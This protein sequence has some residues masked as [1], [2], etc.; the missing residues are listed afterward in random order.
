[1][2]KVAAYLQNHILG[3]VSTKKSS[4]EAVSHDA[5]V[6]RVEPKIVIYPRVTNDI[7][8][9]TR[10]AWQLAEKGHVM[11]ITARGSGTD[12]TGGAIG[13][14]IVL[15]LPAH[16]NRIYELDSK[17]KLLR[18]Q[19]GASGGSI[20]QALSLHGMSVPALPS[21]AAYS[22]IGGAAANNASGTLSGR[23]G[24]IDEWVD[25]LEV[26]LANGDV[27]QTGR[28]SKRDLSK[29][30]GLQGM[31]GDVYRAVDRIIDDNKEAI[32]N[33]TTELRDNVGYG[34]ISQVKRRDGS[35]DL[36][37]LILG[38]QG[39]LGVISEMIIKADYISQE[40]ASLA[41]AFTSR[42]TAV[43]LADKLTGLSPA[44]LECLDGELFQRAETS[45]K[46]YQFIDEAEGPV[47][48]VIMIGFDDFS[49]RSRSR[50]LKRAVK[51]LSQEGVSIVSS[52]DHD[53]ESLRAIRE[54][55]SYS[56]TPAEKDDSAPPIMHGAYVPSNRFE[57][58]WQAVADLASRHHVE[59]PIKRRILDGV[60][61]VYPILKLN[62]VGDKQKLFKILADYASL[63]DSH[64]GHLI[65]EAAEG[66]A[67][68]SFAYK[69]L[70]KAT[71][72]LFE[73]IKAAFDPHGILNPDVKQD[74]QLKQLVS[75]L[76]SDCDTPLASSESLSQ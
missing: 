27:L 63:V 31:E 60:V 73:D 71:L 13:E 52:D 45:G 16:L 46:K 15:V 65:G 48:A 33:I 58:F 28:L 76:R 51:M 24:A 70:D 8:K 22:T 18:V 68:A 54:A 64:G 40:T 12:Q 37:P 36:T 55:T 66:R 62:K 26:V 4:R 17:Q 57:E 75:R 42:E 5:G 1:M 9:V 10:F 2:S 3:E 59:L 32:E 56:L 74:Q 25:R 34:G 30:Q 35:F 11:G 50:K 69:A 44:W 39:T 41:A 23:Y 47:Q 21:S 43:D 29:K 6:L 20:Q 14:G 67:K 61:Y 72:K 19:P 49:A 53:P 7:R 38:S